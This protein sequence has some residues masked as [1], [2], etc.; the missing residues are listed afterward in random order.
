MRVLIFPKEFPSASRPQP[1]IFILRRVQALR[2]LG[3]DVRVLRIVPLAPPITAKWRSYNAIPEEEIYDGVPVK[4]IRAIFPPR[5]LGMEYLPLQV[6]AAV[7]REIRNFQPDILHASF[8]IPSGQI[9][10][11]QNVPVIVTAHGSDAY[12]WPKL[13]AGLHRAAHEAIAKAQRVTAVSGYIARCVQEIVQRPVD[14]VWNG[15]DERFFY[16]RPRDECRE[17]LGLPLD[18]TIVAYAGF[19]LRQKGLFEL[20][21]ALHRIEPPHRPLLVIAGDG[22]DRTALEQRVAELGIEACFLGALPHD[23][24]PLIF[25]AADI[26]TLPSHNEGLPNVVCEAMLCRRAILAT[27]VG[28]IPEIVES[29]RTGLLVPAREP[30][31]LAGALA[32][33][34]HDRVFREAIA[35]RAYAFASQ[36]LT[37]RVSAKR[38]EQIYEETLRSRTPCMS[39]CSSPI[40]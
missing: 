33:L 37:W 15:A 16:P 8:L 39:A 18:R 28:G 29:E 40:P 34:S 31:A 19:A 27:N 9:A 5:M 14:V 6:H 30:H 20:A 2:A 38:Y 13:R 35:E 36:H 7:A 1:G 10:V 12:A 32:R 26:A 21:D 17:A 25:G 3:H 4:S 22:A 11:R 23:R 24:I